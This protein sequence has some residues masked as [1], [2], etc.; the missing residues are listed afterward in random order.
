MIE[1]PARYLW[2]VVGFGLWATALTVIYSYHAVGC[3][4]GWSPFALRA[5]IGAVLLA[6]VVVIWW[7]IRRW[8]GAEGFLAT[9]TQWSLVAALVAT[10]FSY[11]PL[12]VLTTCLP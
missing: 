6:H 3:A 8:R 7:L 1:R 4:Y 5:G 9:L 10:V 2:L 12:V 11:A